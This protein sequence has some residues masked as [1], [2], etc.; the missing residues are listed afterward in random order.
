MVFNKKKSLLVYH[1]TNNKNLFFSNLL[2]V[3]KT[4]FL[5]IVSYKEHHVTECDLTEQYFVF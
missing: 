3:I 4:C 1:F 5:F 2:L